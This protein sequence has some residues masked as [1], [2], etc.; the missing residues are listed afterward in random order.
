MPVPVP[1]QKPAKPSTIPLA[2]GLPTPCPSNKEVP[3]LFLPPAACTILIQHALQPTL[4]KK[5]HKYKNEEYAFLP[6]PT[7]QAPLPNQAGK[8]LPN[9]SPTP[10]TARYSMPT[11]S[12][13]ITPNHPIPHLPSPVPPISGY[14]SPSP[15]GLLPAPPFSHPPESPG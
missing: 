11:S 13:Q 12:I 8:P 10:A 3:P 9:P 14:L 4:L 6:D 15:N 7:L 2:P 1:A 5:H